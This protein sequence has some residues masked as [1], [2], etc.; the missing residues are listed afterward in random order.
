MCF[1]LLLITLYYIYD[2]TKNGEMQ[3]KS[4]FLHEKFK[5]VPHNSDGTY[6]PADFSVG[7]GLQALTKIRAHS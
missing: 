1:L 6:A 2:T 7:T 5:A 3:D 4:P